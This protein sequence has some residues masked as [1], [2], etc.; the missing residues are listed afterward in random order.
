R[1]FKVSPVVAGRRAMDLGFVTPNAFFKF[2]QAYTEVERRPPSP[3]GGGD[4]YNTQNTRI[5]KTF[6]IRVFHAAKAGRLS[7]KEAYA[8]TGLHGGAFQEYARRLGVAFP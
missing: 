2:H 6:A 3:S 4:F 8:L 5:G 1:A 7:F